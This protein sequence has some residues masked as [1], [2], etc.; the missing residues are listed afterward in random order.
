MVFLFYDRG[1]F[2]MKFNL[3]NESEK[4]FNEEKVGNNNPPTSDG[5]LEFNKN[6]RENYETLMKDSSTQLDGYWDSNNPF[7]KIFLLGLLAFI[8]LGVMYYVMTFIGTR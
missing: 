7:V 6:N 2:Y 8:I 3:K 1:D 4:E 5:E